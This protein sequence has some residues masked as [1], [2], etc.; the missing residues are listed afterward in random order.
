MRTTFP[1][2]HAYV[3]A[4]EHD[5]EEAAISI[6][7]MTIQ[8]WERNYETSVRRAY[9]IELLKTHDLLDEFMTRYWPIGFENEGKKQLEF[10]YKL[11]LDYE[12]F[13]DKTEDLADEEQIE[14]EENLTFALENHLR[15]FLAKNLDKIEPGLRLYEL[16]GINGVEFRIDSGRIDL[17]A[18]DKNNSPVIIE[19]KR[20]YGKEKV[21][22]QILYYMAWVDKNLGLGPSRG[23]IISNEISNELKIAIQRA[24]GVELA[25]Y[26]L[27]FSVERA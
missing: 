12:Q 26:K 1:N 15:D 7:S 18:V 13:L 19:L 11:K 6:R 27:Q 24:P 4:K 8:K 5:L 3:Y 10:L 2:K 17:L 22:G 25:V 16:D 20:D 23:I 14:S 21:L 9:L